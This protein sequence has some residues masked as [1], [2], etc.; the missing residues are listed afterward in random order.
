MD[1]VTKPN[2]CLFCGSIINHDLYR[3]ICD[4]CRMDVSIREAIIKA[5]MSERASE[6]WHNV[7]RLWLE[8]LGMAVYFPKYSFIH[9]QGWDEYV[10]N[11][12][13]YI[14]TNDARERAINYVNWP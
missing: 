2:R 3:I 5:P 6:F 12:I 10:E 8:N 11:A 9:E 13:Q 14:E 7:R 4:P 1:H